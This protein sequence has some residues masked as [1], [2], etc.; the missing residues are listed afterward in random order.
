MRGSRLAAERGLGAPDASLTGSVGVLAVGELL[1]RLG[2]IE[3][4]DAGIGP[5]KT[6]ARGITGRELVAG[7]AQ[8]QLLD[9]EF[10]A[11][12]DRHR[13]GAAAGLLSAV[14][15]VAST[16]AGGLTR[17]SPRTGRPA[18]RPATPPSSPAHGP[19]CPNKVG[20]RCRPDGW[21]ST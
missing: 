21:R 14:P 13:T 2:V 11:A 6:R 7:L 10:F 5:I 18:S 4:L 17:A 1:D 20:R 9:G 19:G 12:L 8:C 3:V 15:A 16:T